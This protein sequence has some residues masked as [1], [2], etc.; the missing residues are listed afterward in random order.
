M[1]TSPQQIEGTGISVWNNSP[2]RTYSLQ[3]GRNMPVLRC[4][5]RLLRAA[6]LPT[7]R[8]NSSHLYSTQTDDI[9]NSS[10]LAL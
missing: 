8:S 5:D 2:D 6:V 10:V 1:K 3:V 9:L 7:D 4:A